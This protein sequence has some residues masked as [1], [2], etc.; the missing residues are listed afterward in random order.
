MQNILTSTFLFSHSLF[1]AYLFLPQCFS[2]FLKSRLLI[3]SIFNKLIFNN[4]TNTP[5]DQVAYLNAIHDQIGLRLTFWVNT[6][7]S[8]F[9]IDSYAKEMQNPK[10]AE[11]LGNFAYIGLQ[12]FDGSPK[13]A[14]EIWDSF[15]ETSP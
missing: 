6:L 12:N 9:N 1:F 14:L 8:D 15:R 2:I 10:D 3:I 11:T 4:L 7:M 5:Q 13:P